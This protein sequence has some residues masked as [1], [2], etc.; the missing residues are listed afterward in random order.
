MDQVDTLGRWISHYIAE[1]MASL[2]GKAGLERVDAEREIA[3]LILRLWALRC[4]HPGDRKPFAEIDAVEA[5]IARLA[6]G[7]NKWSFSRAFTADTEPDGETTSTN[8]LL[9]TALLIDELSRDLVRGLVSYAAF[10]A[11]ETEARWVT[12]AEKIEDSTLLRIRRLVNS[13]QDSSEDISV[14]E[15]QLQNVKEKTARLLSLT[16]DLA[17]AL[18]KTD[19]L[20]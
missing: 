18:D 4:E 14:E 16:A 19:S 1:K 17:A 12:H 2:P 7:Q 6:P 10:C 9:Q 8:M 5:G 11:E 15:S 20:R 3:D 13:G